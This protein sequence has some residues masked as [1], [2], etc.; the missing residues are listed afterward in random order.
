M[1]YYHKPAWMTKNKINEPE[2][3]WECVHTHTHTP[4][5][6]NLKSLLLKELYIV[7]SNSSIMTPNECNRMPINR[8]MDKQTEWHL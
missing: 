7:A 5:N 4:N 8:W 3:I 6:E 2:H 1:R